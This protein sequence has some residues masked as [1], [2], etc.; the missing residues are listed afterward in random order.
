MWNEKHTV[1]D[2][3]Y[4][5]KQWKTLNMRNTHYRNWIVARKIKNGE[6]E[7]QTLYDLEYRKCEKNE[8]WEIHTVGPRFGEKTEK[9][10]K[11]DTYTVWHGIWRNTMKN[12]KNEKCQ[13]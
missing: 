11:W 5:K 9:S 6:N 3:E 1:Y 7:T 4:G 13:L 8:L 12:E 2:M 10:W